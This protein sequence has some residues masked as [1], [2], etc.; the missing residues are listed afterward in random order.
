MQVVNGNWGIHA[1]LKKALCGR[2]NLHKP[3]DT[4]PLGGGSVA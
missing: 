2:R 3:T 1:I 4:E